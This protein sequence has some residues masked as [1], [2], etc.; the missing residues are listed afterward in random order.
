MEQKAVRLTVNERTQKGRRKNNQD[1]AINVEVVPGHVYLVGVA[2]GM[3]GYAGG[4]QASAIALKHI[5]LFAESIRN[6]V[7]ESD[8]KAIRFLRSRILDVFD[9]IQ[10]D[11]QNTAAIEPTLSQM[12]TTLVLACVAGRN[13]FVAN[14]GDSRAYFLYKTNEGR[15]ILERV[16]EDHTVANDARRAGERILL[17]SP[18]ARKLARA[19]TRALRPNTPSSPELWPPDNAAAP[20]FQAATGDILLIC[21]D[22]MYGSVPLEE[23]EV[24][25][26]ESPSLEESLKRLEISALD[27]GSTDNITT[28]AVEFGDRDPSRKAAPR[29]VSAQMLDDTLQEQITIS[30]RITIPPGMHLESLR[31]PTPSTPPAPPVKESK[32]E[33]LPPPMRPMSG[34]HPTV[35]PASAPRPTAKASSKAPERSRYNPVLIIL[36]LVVMAIAGYAIASVLQSKPKAD[37]STLTKKAPGASRKAPAAAPSPNVVIEETSSKD[38]PSISSPSSVTGEAT[39]KEHVSSQNN[40]RSTRTEP[41]RSIQTPNHSTSSTTG[42]RRIIRDTASA[43][44]KASKKTP[45]PIKVLNPDKG[46]NLEN[47]KKSSPIDDPASLGL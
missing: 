29:S 14:I 34:A 1:T 46:G 30:E 21:S 25:L 36:G 4:E 28:V 8:S 17:E 10:H 5:L 7:P 35:T 41:R 16:T 37:K 38:A 6:Q 32:S 2:D 27:G 40:T 24:I 31:L 20:A 33:T 26:I 9:D 42:N 11:I 13:F 22:G 45:E 47:T 43:T 3:G 15:D 23:M 18:E 12:G 44:P 39:P 19:L